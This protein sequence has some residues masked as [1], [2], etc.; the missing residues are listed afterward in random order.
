[1]NKK[2]KIIVIVIIVLIIIILGLW[3]SGIIPKQIAKNSA[4][5]YLKEKFPEKQYEYEQI[6]WAPSFGG[7]D[8]KFKDEN[9]KTVSFI[10]YG[11]FF[12][13]TPTDGTNELEESNNQIEST[14]VYDENGQVISDLSKKDEVIETEEN[15]SIQEVVEL[16]HNGY[17]YIFNGQHFGEFGFEMDE[18]TTANI[19][20]K[21]QKCIDYLTLEE[22]DTSYIQE[23]DILICSGDLNKKGYGSN[24]DTK[25]KPIIVLK[26][27]DYNKM[28]QEALTDNRKYQSVVTIGESYIESGYIYLKYTLKDDTHSD[29]G[30]NFPFAVKAYITENTIEKGKLKDGETVKVEYENLNAPLDELTIKSI[31]V[32]EKE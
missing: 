1:M 25:D 30:Y 19:V 7:Y 24:F 21:K 29:T 27:N 22:H 11:R 13:V 17:I 32:I 20:D 9:G 15:I 12:P 31:E 23:G 6:E 16:H 14:P 26:S 3:I 18:Y 2:I 4:E 5:K 10:M 28:K 8:I